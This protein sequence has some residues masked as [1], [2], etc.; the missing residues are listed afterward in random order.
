MTEIVAWVQNVPWWAAIAAY[1]DTEVAA[2]ISLLDDARSEPGQG[3]PP[4]N[5]DLATKIDYL[6]KVWRNKKTQTADTFTLFADDASTA[7]QAATVSDAAGT[8]TFGEMGSG[9]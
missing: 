9:A 3:A 5:P 4:V 6:Y 7:D 2:I 8:A 1:V